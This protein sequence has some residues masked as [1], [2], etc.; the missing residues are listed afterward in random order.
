[1]P[2]SGKEE[3]GGLEGKRGGNEPS[4]E[5][6]ETGDAMR[7]STAAENRANTAVHLQQY[8]AERTAAARTAAART[9]ATVGVQTAAAHLLRLRLQQHTCSSMLQSVLLQQYAHLL[10]QFAYVLQL[11]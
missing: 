1:M 7:S 4:S 9:A 3:V 8:A 6:G 11:L 10:Q 2:S 5:S